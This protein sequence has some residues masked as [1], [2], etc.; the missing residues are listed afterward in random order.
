MEAKLCPDGSSVGRTG[1]DCGFAPCPDGAVYCTEESRNADV[2]I[3]LYQPVCGW[4][5]LEVQC[6][7]YP[8]ASTFSNS[9]EAC[10]SPT[11]D[12]YTPG[13]C[14]SSDAQIANPASTYCIENGGTLKILETEGGQYGVCTI[15]GTDCEEWAHFR[16]ECPSG[17]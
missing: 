12:Y 6:V 10:K 14:P 1:P 13:E 4:F 11:V 2:C 17:P 9:C 5:G 8:C 16:G 7:R 3:R 15:N